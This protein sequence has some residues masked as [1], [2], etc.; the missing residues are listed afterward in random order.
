MS[1]AHF[2]LKKKRLEE[3]KV[4][5]PIEMWTHMA[6]AVAG[7]L[8]DSISSAFSQMLIVSSTEPRTLRNCDP[9]QVHRQST[10]ENSPI[11]RTVP[12]RPMPRLPVQDGTN[13]AH[14]L[15]VLKS[16]MPTMGP[17]GGLPAPSQVVK[18]LIGKIPSQHQPSSTAGVSFAETST[19]QSAATS[20]HLG[21]AEKLIVSSTSRQS[22]SHIVNQV[23]GHIS[24]SSMRTV[25]VKSQRNGSPVILTTQ[26]RSEPQTTSICTSSVIKSISSSPHTPVCSSTTSL[27]SVA[28]SVPASVASSSSAT[29]GCISAHTVPPLSTPATVFHAMFGRTSKYATTDSPRTFG[30]KCVVDFERIYHYLSVIHKPEKDCHLTPMESAIVLDLLMSLSEELSLLD[31]KKLHKHM[32]QVYHSLSS[33]DSSIASEMF[34]HLTDGVSVQTEAQRGEERPQHTAQNAESSD[35]MDSGGTK[36]QPNGEGKQGAPEKTISHSVEADIMGC[37]P[38]L[39]PFLVPLKLLMRR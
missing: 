20:Y 35:V 1:C 28:S 11:G 36:L 26:Q 16:P 3:K 32:I 15:L 14:S 18:M 21:T 10:G 4:K 34:K 13:T 25:V 7:T 37:C 39:N 12:F 31:C 9:P 6:S 24:A 23:R 5:K 19:S 8:E 38:P 22:T 30:V 17:A 29:S 27:I 33:A 2:K